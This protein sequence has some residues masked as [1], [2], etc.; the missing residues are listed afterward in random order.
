MMP[1]LMV[2][3]IFIIYTLGINDHFNFTVFDNVFSFRWI[4]NIDFYADRKM[5]KACRTTASGAL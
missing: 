1:I 3:L 5:V 4:N 2:N